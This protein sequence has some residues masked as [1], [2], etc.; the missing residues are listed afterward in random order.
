V[1]PATGRIGGRF[2][3]V[4]G[5][6]KKKMARTTYFNVRVLAVVAGLA[7]AACLLALVVRV[8]PSQAA[9]PGQN[10]KI[11]F[12]SN[13]DS[14]RTEIYTMNADGTNPTR[15]TN[16]ETHDVSPTFSAD[17][18]KIAFSRENDPSIED[19][20][21]W[22]MN[23]DGSGQTD[24]NIP[25]IFSKDEGPS[26][27][28]D[29]SKIAFSRVLFEGEPPFN[30]DIWVMNA[31]GSGQ[32]NLSD[33]P[34][35]E[36]YMPEFSPDGTKI[37]FVSDQDGDPD[38]FNAMEIYVMNADGSGTPTNLSNNPG[39][40]DTAPSFS[41][42]GSKIAFETYRDGAPE[43]Y[44]MNADGSGTSTNLSNNPGSP[45]DSTAYDRHPAWS[46]DG[47]RIAFESL[48]SGNSEIWVMNAD[49]TGE[50]VNV[51]N[52]AAT[53]DYPDWQPLPNN[54]APTITNLSPAP[55]ST[56]TDLTPTISATVTDQQTNLTQRD[57]TLKLDGALVPPKRY[58]YNRNTDTLSY[59][60]AKKLSYAAHSVE[61][62]ATDDG[63]LSTPKS[64]SFKIVHP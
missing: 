42:D 43:I 16:N 4:E 41:P 12:I 29:G 26:F 63:G 19:N 3:A 15:L 17:G 60:P 13:R 54:T 23:A 33:S 21:I 2:C 61:V 38:P 32:T 7:L 27:S 11:A 34:A 31:D 49:G 53:D 6:E 24:L 1:Q 5:E 59:T 62:V 47:T 45:S 37:A 20:N 10:G 46:P 22:V 64:W 40:N 18:K 50:P 35:S 39:S 36:D 55:D 25:D 56:T 14:A 28:P 9:F 51:S 8:E 52:N 58:S 48:R 30:D 44:V 57:I